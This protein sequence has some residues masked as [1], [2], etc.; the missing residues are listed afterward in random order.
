MVTHMINRCF[1][2]K[3]DITEKECLKRTIKD[4]TSSC[5]SCVCSTVPIPRDVSDA[6]CP[7]ASL[8]RVGQVHTDCTDQIWTPRKMYDFEYHGRL[9]T[10][11]PSLSSQYS[12]IGMRASVKLYAKT[13]NTIVLKVEDPKYVDVNHVLYPKERGAAQTYKNDGWNW[14]NLYLPPLKDVSWR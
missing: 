14:R 12:G 1:T 8:T 5:K 2:A 9:L 11:L 10:G 4:L 7:E 3:M 13:S 6:V